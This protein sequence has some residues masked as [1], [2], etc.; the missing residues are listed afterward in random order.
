MPSENWAK[1]MKHDKHNTTQ[2]KTTQHNTTGVRRF[3]IQTK[4]SP[5][6]FSADTIS[7]TIILR[8]KDGPILLYTDSSENPILKILNA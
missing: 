3:Y 6:K 7:T 8:W 5:E 1:A 4:P 2:H